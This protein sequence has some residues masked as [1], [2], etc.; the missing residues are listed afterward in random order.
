VARRF[1][2]LQVIFGWLVLIAAFAKAIHDYSTLA[3]LQSFQKLFLPFVLTVLTLPFMYAL[4][5]YALYDYLFIWSAYKQPRELTRYMKLRAFRYGGL[6]LNRATHL[7]KISPYEFL[8]VRSPQDF[9]ALITQIE[10]REE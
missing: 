7:A 4:A 10:K 1:G 9:D 3:T 6:N 5:L 2:Y 8:R